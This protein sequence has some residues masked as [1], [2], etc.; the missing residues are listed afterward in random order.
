MD[1]HQDRFA[2]FR[3]LLTAPLTAVVLA[4]YALGFTVANRLD[5]MSYQAWKYTYGT[6]FLVIDVL[7]NWTIGTFIWWERPREW[8]FTERLQRHARGGRG[9]ACILCRYLSI[10]DEDHCGLGGDQ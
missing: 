1:L 2:L 8:V 4:L 3:Y 10:W 5:G 9:F 6:A 7:Y